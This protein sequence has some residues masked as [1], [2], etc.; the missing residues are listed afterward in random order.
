MPAS[1]IP[2]L[3]W[4]RV[5]EAAARTESFA[6]AAELLN[7]SA[8]AVSQQI[9]ALETHLGRDLFVREAKRVVLTET[10]RSF[11]PA[12][13][14]SLYSVETTAAA[15]FGTREEEQ[16][17]I[18]MVSVLAIGWLAPRLARFEAAHPGI[19][20]NVNTANL[21]SD[22]RAL[23]PGRDADLQVAFGSAT[24][25]PEGAER[26]M[27]ETLYAV[28]PPQIAEAIHSPKDISGH[29]LNEV[30][31]HRSGWHQV[32]SGADGT[33]IGQCRLRMVDNTPLSLVLSAS[34]DGLALARAPATDFLTGR[35][36]LAAVGALAPVRGN[37]HYH[38]FT[39]QTRPL[40]RAR[41]CFATG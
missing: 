3:N 38:L 5:F 11:L 13:Q 6:R 17:T 10:G 4:L 16:V 8:A 28:A 39:S 22:F 23:L 30:A 19:R 33:D 41:S 27:G 37:Q 1:R 14:Q 9:K 25:F 20:V 21:V 40:E 34:G 7:M 36:G 31:T 35:L 26:L 2:S 32:L 29:L 24:D 15:L 12:V 18:Q